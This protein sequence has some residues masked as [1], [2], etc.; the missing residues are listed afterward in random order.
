NED[1]VLNIFKIKNRPQFNPIIIHVASINKMQEFVEYIPEKLLLLVKH[2]TPGPLTFLL[3]K[4]NIVPDLVTAGS[5]KVAVRIPNH[6]LTLSLLEQLDFPL[7]APSANPFGYVSPT[8]AQH[9][10]DSLHGLIPH[11][12]DGGDCKI[13]LESTIIGFDEN[14]KVIVHRIGGTSVEDIEKVLTEKVIFDIAADK[15]SSPGQLKSHYATN[16]PLYVGD[17]DSLL[18]TFESRK[19][20]VISLSKVYPDAKTFMLSQK[21]DINE[22][23]RNLFKT[24]RLLDKNDFEVILAEKFPDEGLGRAINDRL[25]RAQQKNK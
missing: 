6:R 22:A 5:D 25:A 10:F 17:V 14:S 13:G 7:A 18:K 23:A 2:F 1:A 16:T 12:L 3:P 9:V 11:I 4:K 20:A 19:I 15:P 8:T 24:L 21:Q